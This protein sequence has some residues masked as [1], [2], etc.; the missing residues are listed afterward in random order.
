MASCP[1][2]LVGFPVTYVRLPFFRTSVYPLFYQLSGTYVCYVAASCA[3]STL[4]YEPTN[5]VFISAVS[6]FL[7]YH[8]HFFLNLFCPDTE[9]FHGS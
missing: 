9:F 3:I 7:S 5:Y 1:D 4:Y 8:R 2:C 6:L